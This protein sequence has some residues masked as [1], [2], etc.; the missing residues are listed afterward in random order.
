[1]G[2]GELKAPGKDGGPGAAANEG[3]W[4]G[5]DIPS[6]VRC[7]TMA[8]DPIGIARGGGLVAGSSTTGSKVEPKGP[9]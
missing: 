2:D 3:P 9:A 1:M 4:K 8:G 6:G 7:A 5:R